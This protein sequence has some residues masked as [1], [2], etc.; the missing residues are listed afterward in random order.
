MATAGAEDLSMI[1][2]N[3]YTPTR[4]WLEAFRKR[5]NELIPL[6]YG[7]LF[8]DVIL[9]RHPQVQPLLA[10]TYLFHSSTQ[11]FIQ[12]FPYDTHFGSL[13][14]ILFDANPFPPNSDRSTAT[15]SI[16]LNPTF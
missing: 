7:Y 14:I 13:C 11:P 15:M 4:R 9:N 1:S 6:I 3:Y 12:Q 16:C 8:Y 5:D 10:I 2:K